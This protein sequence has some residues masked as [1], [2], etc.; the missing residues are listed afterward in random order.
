M[1]K[2]NGRWIPNPDQRTCP[3]R[4]LGCLGCEADDLSQ[5]EFN[6]RIFGAQAA[7]R[8]KRAHEAKRTGRHRRSGSR[9]SGRTS[10]GVSGHQA[11]RHAAHAAGVN[12]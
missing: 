5:L 2:L 11:V 8:D 3:A 6:R 12:A 10:A 7:I 4:G 9:T 1:I